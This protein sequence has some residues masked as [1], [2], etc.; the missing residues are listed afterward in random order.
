[1]FL[2][3]KM[4]ELETKKRIT[5]EELKKIIDDINNMNLNLIINDS[6]INLNLIK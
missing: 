3:K 1:M 2:I 6:S 4:I 5:L